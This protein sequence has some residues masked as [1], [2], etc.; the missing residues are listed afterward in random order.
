MRPATT[1]RGTADALALVLIAPACVALAVL[2]ASLG[3]NVDS[4]AQARSAAESAAQA[5]ALERDP[6]M[7]RRVAERIVAE[8]LIDVETCA[9][10]VVDVDTDALHPGGAVSVVV[11]CTA[12]SRGADLMPSSRR[13]YSARAVAHVDPYRSGD[14]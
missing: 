2:V 1:D 8:M 12:S 4:R 7:A 10:P 14:G 6:H 9:S 3:R 13:T 5:A 11:E